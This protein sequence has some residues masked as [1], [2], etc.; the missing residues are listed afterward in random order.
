[1]KDA[2][3]TLQDRLAPAEDIFFTWLARA[4]LAAVLVG[5]AWIDDAPPL[6]LA[7]MLV[8]VY[9]AV[10]VVMQFGPL[11]AAAPFGNRVLRVLFAGGA[12][13]VLGLAFLVVVTLVE[14]LGLLAVGG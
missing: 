8:A 9:V 14:R 13:V 3:R 6:E 2:I 7:A 11:A 1:M 4:C 5:S 12:V 10:R